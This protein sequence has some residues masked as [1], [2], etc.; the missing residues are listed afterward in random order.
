M[1]RLLLYVI[2]C[3]FIIIQALIVL[4]SL[5]WHGLSNI[6]P[7]HIFFRTWDGE[8]LLL[9]KLGY[10]IGIMISMWIYGIIGYIVLRQAKKQPKT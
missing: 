4:S 1:G 6:I 10:F 3:I 7:I 8:Y 9:Q 2:A 5:Y